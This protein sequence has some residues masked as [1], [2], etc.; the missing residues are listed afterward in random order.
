[1]MNAH[2][3]PNP[4]V[5]FAVQPHQLLMPVPQEQ[6]DASGGRLTQTPATKTRH[7]KNMKPFL[8]G[9]GC[10]AYDDHARFCST[11][12]VASRADGRVC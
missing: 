3:Y 10:G 9:I 1:M 4:N 12:V 11:I 2:A 8:L 6:L 7:R 5:T